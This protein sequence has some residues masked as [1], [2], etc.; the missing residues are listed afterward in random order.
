MMG[1]MS[2]T[3]TTAAEGRCREALAAAAARRTPAT[4]ARRAAA[5]ALLVYRL[6][7]CF[8]DTGRVVKTHGGDHP[9]VRVPDGEDVETFLA[10]VA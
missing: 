1:D 8:I 3:I 10:G 9:L 4:E 6:G 2:I 7:R 5:E